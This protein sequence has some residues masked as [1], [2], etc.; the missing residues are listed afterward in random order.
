MSRQLRPGIIQQ[1]LGEDLFYSLYAPKA[2]WSLSDESGLI[3]HPLEVRNSLG[4]T[5]DITYDQITNGYAITLAN[6]GD[7][8]LKVMKIHEQGGSA[9]YLYQNTY[10]K[11]HFLVKDGVLQTVNGLPALFNNVTTSVYESVE[12]DTYYGNNPEYAII[13]MVPDFS[14]D[15]SFYI[16]IFGTSTARSTFNTRLHSTIPTIY[17]LSTITTLTPT[18]GEAMLLMNSGKLHLNKMS[19][20][21]TDWDSTVNKGVEPLGVNFRFFG[22]GGGSNSSQNALMGFWQEISVW[23]QGSLTNIYDEV[24][25]NRM[26]KYIP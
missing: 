24:R 25:T 20:N 2:M 23:Q 17:F 11:A 22:R 19:M 1:S 12:L 3:T 7:G 10:S 14:L 18:E 26:S 15:T 6:L 16:T 13:T 4:T 9:N 8:N 5:E 21:T